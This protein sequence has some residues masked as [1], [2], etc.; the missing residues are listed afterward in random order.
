MQELEIKYEVLHKKLKK[1]Q[2][3]DVISVVENEYQNEE[4][5]PGFRLLGAIAYYYLGKYNFTIQNCSG[6]IDD[7]ESGRN[8]FKDKIDYADTYYFRGLS[9]LKIEHNKKAKKDFLSALN[10]SKD[11][12]TVKLDLAELLSFEQES[13]E[14]AID[15]VNEAYELSDKTDKR[16]LSLVKFTMAK[17]LR[18]YG[19]KYFEPLQAAIDFDV[20]N[21][22]AH[23]LLG[24][25]YNESENIGQAISAFKLAI[26]TGAC[27]KAA[28]FK[29]IDLLT[30]LGQN[31]EAFVLFSEY[32][33]KQK[34]LTDKNSESPF[35]KK[36]MGDL[37]ELKNTA[38]ELLTQIGE[39]EMPKLCDG[40]IEG[41]NN[42]KTFCE[43]PSDQGVVHYTKLKHLYSMI[44][45]KNGRLRLYNV[46]YANDYYEGVIFP[47]AL[48]AE[49]NRKFTELL[50]SSPDSQNIYIGSFLPYSGQSGSRYHD[51][52][53]MWRFYGKDEKGTQAAGCS[54]V[55]RPEFFK[56]QNR[57]S[58]E[59]VG[60]GRGIMKVYRIIYFNDET[61]KFHCSNKI[62][63]KY[64]EKQVET[65]RDAFLS[66]FDKAKR[67]DVLDAVN[68]F[69][70][71]AISEIRYFFKSDEFAAE[72]E[73]RIII[74]AL[75]TDEK[76]VI[77]DENEGWPRRVYYELDCDL[78]QNIHKIILGPKAG[79]PKEWF[80]LEALLK[81]KL[82]ENAALEK[83]RIQF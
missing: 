82:C 11:F 22:D 3:D 19:D 59:R 75:P 30:R 62:E 54:L 51:R 47:K 69:F 1:G 14:L 73:C 48:K 9:Y 15:L 56:I 64:I 37:Y 77:S 40:I 34:N 12:L 53:D 35:P 6:L 74:Y 13:K 45:E 8:L 67:E 21:S 83:S 33:E 50:N 5:F 2:Y 29:V 49:L 7:L 20:L 72:N 24:I 39:Y 52:L 81:R 41:I 27:N 18:N 43:Y 10:L 31:D 23:F 44:D 76:V 79:D 70:Y 57:N 71:R 63:E 4:E 32:I 66:L 61:G 46:T 42:V 28:Y 60:Q 80:F 58:A 25:F 38:A 68:I 16:Q 55:I 36:D 78:N 17:V 26:Q 65:I